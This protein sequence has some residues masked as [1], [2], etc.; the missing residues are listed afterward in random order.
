MRPF[1]WRA[2]YVQ[3]NQ[4]VHQ[5]YVG[6]MPAVTEKKVSALG[7]STRKGS[8]NIQEPFQTLLLWLCEFLDHHLQH[9]RLL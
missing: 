8:T 1:G 6:I 4:R 2:E 9:P 7:Q 5:D 3:R